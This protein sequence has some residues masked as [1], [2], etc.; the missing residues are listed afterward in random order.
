[1]SSRGPVSE[2]PFFFSFAKRWSDSYDNDS[3]PKEDLPYVKELR[4]LLSEFEVGS[5]ELFMRVYED[6]FI[7]PLLETII[8]LYGNIKKVDL[9]EPTKE[10]IWLDDR[11]YSAYYPNSSTSLPIAELRDS[12]S[13]PLPEQSRSNVDQDA[14]TNSN[15]GVRGD[16]YSQSASARYSPTSRCPRVPLTAKMLY[17][18]LSEEVFTP[19]FPDFIGFLVW[20]LGAHQSHNT[21]STTA[22]SIVL[23]VLQKNYSPIL[24]DFFATP[25]LTSRR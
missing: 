17:T 24:L 15:P 6:D 14:A 9:D 19:Q 4:L 5:I 12:G 18:F 22:Y 20:I 13:A 11:T 3:I 7:S 21:V 16:A 2:K 10:T 25:S 23:L 1:M 8:R